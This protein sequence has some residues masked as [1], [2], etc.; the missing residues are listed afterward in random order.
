MNIKR[1]EKKRLKN[2]KT[3][4][5]KAYWSG[6]VTNQESPTARGKRKKSKKATSANRNYV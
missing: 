1:D 5:T 2:W 6:L 3:V 4:I